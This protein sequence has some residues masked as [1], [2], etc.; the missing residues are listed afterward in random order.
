M[1][2]NKLI[3]H[4]KEIGQKRQQ[5]LGNYQQKYKTIQNLE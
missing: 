5:R 3:E 1:A 2:A 4:V